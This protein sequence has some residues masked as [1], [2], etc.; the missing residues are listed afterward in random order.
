MNR[1]TDWTADCPADC[2]A[3]SA[4][5][6]VLEPGPNGLNEQGEIIARVTGLLEELASREHWDQEIAFRANLILEELVL[7]AM[8][9][10][11]LEPGQAPRIRVRLESSP[12]EIVLEVMDRGRPFDPTR[13]APPPPRM[14]GGK[15][16]AVTPGGLGIHLAR[17]LSSRM[18]HHRQDDGWNRTEIMLERNPDG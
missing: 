1:S 5:E 12:G 18:T 16:S 14:G 10:G 2:P 13:D 8:T 4:S 17:S 7:N 11:A 3:N 9:H 15:A 6:L